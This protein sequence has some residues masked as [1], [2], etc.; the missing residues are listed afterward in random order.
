MAEQTKEYRATLKPEGVRGKSIR[1]DELREV[2]HVTSRPNAKYAWAAGV[3]MSRFLDELKEGRIVGRKC[4]KCA[5][6]LVPPR[7]FCERCYRQTD[8]WVELPGTAVIE[9]FAVSYLDTDANRIKEPILVGVVDLDG[10]PPH[11]GF[12]HYF[13]EMSPDEIHIGM[14]VEA[15]WKPKEER[16]GAITDIR[17]FRPR[18]K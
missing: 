17:Y 14:P 13:D 7:M 2:P 12:M 6:V 3:A 8:E 10:A 18:R 11:C 4:R 5:R 1:K 16:D 15:V 9:T